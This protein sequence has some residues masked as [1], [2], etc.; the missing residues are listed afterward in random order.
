MQSRFSEK[1][2]KSLR[3]FVM[4]GFLGLAILMISTALQA[5]QYSG[6]ITGSVTDSSGAAVS[7]AAITV[8]NVGTNATYNATASDDGVFT[9]AQLPVGIYEVRIKANNFKEYVAKGVEVHTSSNAQISAK[10]DVGA[11]TESVT[12]EA[13][14]V[15]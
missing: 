13:G 10:L 1:V 4:Q 5:Q 3:P 14:A 9:I 7:G 15:Q 11:V 2:L 8:T 6:T 12:V